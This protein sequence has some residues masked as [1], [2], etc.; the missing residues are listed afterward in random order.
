MDQMGPL[1][2]K[3][4]VLKNTNRPRTN[5][6]ATLIFSS[7]GFMLQP[8]VKNTTVI[9]LS[10]FTNDGCARVTVL[11]LPCHAVCA[12]TTEQRDI[13]EKTRPHLCLKQKPAMDISRDH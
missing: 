6:K 8:N 13:N 11:S 2:Y 4:R 9:S 5:Y 1:N 10:I 3:I 7:H 12:M